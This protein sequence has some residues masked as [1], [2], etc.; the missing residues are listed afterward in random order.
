MRR[1]SVLGR[2]GGS[3][4]LYFSGGTL[5][6]AAANEQLVSGTG[7]AFVSSGGA[8][9][10][11]NG[12]NVTIGTALQ[13]DPALGG[14]EDGGLIKTGN[15]SLTLDGADTYTGPTTVS[16]GTLKLDPATPGTKILPPRRRA[17]DRQQRD[18]WI[19]SAARNLSL[20]C[21]APAVL[22]NRAGTL[23]ELIVSGSA[24]TTFSG[25]I[26]AAGSGGI[27]LEMLGPGMLILSG[28]DTYMGGTTVDGGMLVVAQIR[29]SPTARTCS[30]A[31]RHFLVQSSPTRQIAGHLRWRGCLPC[32]RAG[33][34]RDFASDFFCAGAVSYVKHRLSSPFRR[35]KWPPKQ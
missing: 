35:R 30:S 14:A 3:G 5:A 16:G 7:A 11:S 18:A 28:T 4:T 21:R 22:V 29:P 12:F 1:R 23:A 6:A 9:L 34:T 2:S 25:S 15:G 10:N 31:K 32:A 33:D 17:G 19:S 8:V 27:A 13:H 20:R 26:R 24:T